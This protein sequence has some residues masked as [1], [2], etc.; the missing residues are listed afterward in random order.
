MAR[1]DHLTYLWPDEKRKT[2]TAEEIKRHKKRLKTRRLTVRSKET[3]N[4]E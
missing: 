2:L 4:K 3:E 1:N